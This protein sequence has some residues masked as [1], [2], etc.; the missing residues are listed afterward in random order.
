MSQKTNINDIHPLILPKASS[1]AIRGKQSVRATF[2]LTEKCIHAINI[3]AT[4]L[5]IK[6]K[7][8]FDHLI[9][10]TDALKSI[11]EGSRGQIVR[12][13]PVISKT[14][15]ISRNS[16]DVLNK[17]SK[18]YCISKES[19]IELS[20]QRL[21]PIIAKEKVTH[22]ERKKYINQINEHLNQGKSIHDKI[23]KHFGSS[24]IIY[25]KFDQVMTNYQH[26]IDEIQKYIDK[27][28]DIESFKPEQF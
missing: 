11:A 6:K 25:Q 20:V 3:V 10:D 19:L 23:K 17:M 9:E 5:G 7:S 21:L 18:T 13:K 26:C 14:F 15:V 28:R 12:S 8:L 1:G 16:F 2:K 4:H 22:K 27:S 24:D